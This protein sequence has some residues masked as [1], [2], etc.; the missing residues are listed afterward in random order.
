MKLIYNDVNITNDIKIVSAS[1]IDTCGG[2][3][4][5]IQCTFSDTEKNWRSWAPEKGDRLILSKDK[6]SSGVM[7]ADEFHISRGIYR[8]NAISTPLGIKTKK[9]RSWESINFNKLANDLASEIGLKVETYYTT[10]WIYKRID[11][12]DETNMELLNKIC[13]LEG[14]SLKITNGKVVIYD[15]RSLESAASTLDISESDII[16]DYTFSNVSSGIY[17]ACSLEYFSFDNELIKYTY[18]SPVFSDYPIL[19]IKNTKV[20]DYAEAERF[21]KNLLRYNNKNEIKG[22]FFVKLNSEIGAGNIVNIKQMGSFNGKYFVE[23]V[24]QGITN[25][26]S[27]LEI[28][29]V[30]EG[31]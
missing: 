17:S 11:Q 10:D 31:Y 21:S 20:S 8:I 29:K 22:S 26:K 28:R 24:V 4:D 30:L 23:K 6:F 1:I 3:A 7:Y 14:Y 15:E 19:K 27:K 2:G 12:I 25:G 9:T 18:N 13:I 16:G 5:S